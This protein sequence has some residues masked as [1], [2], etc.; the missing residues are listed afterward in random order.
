MTVETTEVLVPK[1]DLLDQID[2]LPDEGEI[3]GVTVTTTGV[4]FRVM[5]TDMDEELDL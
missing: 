1:R 4:G 2:A 5:H 3:Y